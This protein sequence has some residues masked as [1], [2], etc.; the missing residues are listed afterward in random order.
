MESSEMVNPVTFPGVHRRKCPN[1]S[2]EYCVWFEACQ[3]L[4]LDK[5]AI[6]IALAPALINLDVAAG[7]PAEFLKLLQ[8]LRV[9][10]LRGSIARNPNERDK[11][12]RLS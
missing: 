2:N 5:N 6:H 9:G 11:A 1:A 12:T 10:G 7:G 3:F 8:E 4:R